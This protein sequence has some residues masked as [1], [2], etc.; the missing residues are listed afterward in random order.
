M[1][2]V[3]PRRVDGLNILLSKIRPFVL[4]RLK[5]QLEETSVS[6]TIPS[7]KFEF[8]MNLKKVLIDVSRGTRKPKVGLK[9]RSTFSNALKLWEL[10]KNLWSRCPGCPKCIIC[11]SNKLGRFTL[12]FLVARNS[13]CLTDWFSDGFG[14]VIHRFGIIASDQFIEEGVWRSGGVEHCAEGIHWSHRVWNCCCCCHRW[15]IHLSTFL[16]KTYRIWG[17]QKNGLT[18]ILFLGYT[19]K[20]NTSLMRVPRCRFAMNDALVFNLVM[21]ILWATAKRSLDVSCV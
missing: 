7:F 10:H 13:Q 20:I 11:F 14:T 3:L 8:T 6:V 19:R 18:T 5:W 16:F 15:A 17:L 1:Y 12:I 2:I 4:R 9:S 21:R